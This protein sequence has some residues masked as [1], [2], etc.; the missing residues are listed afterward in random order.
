MY[1]ED[2]LKYRLRIIEEQEKKKLKIVEIPY[3]E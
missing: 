1:F 3:N 2:L